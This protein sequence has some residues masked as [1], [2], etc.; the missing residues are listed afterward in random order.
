[1][2]QKEK[3]MFRVFF[4]M[5]LSLARNGGFVTQGVVRII[6]APFTSLMLVIFHIC[7]HIDYVCTHTGS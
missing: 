5:P 7:I 1:M 6:R 4:S 3:K 2:F